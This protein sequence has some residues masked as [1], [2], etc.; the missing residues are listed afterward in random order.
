VVE[1]ILGKRA[2]GTE[3]PMRDVARETVE[4]NR[5]DCRIE[6]C[7]MLADQGSENSRQDI[8]ISADR[9]ARITGSI[10]MQPTAVGDDGA[11]SFENHD[12]SRFA[13]DLE[14]T[15]LLLVAIGCG[16]TG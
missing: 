11:V 4:I 9:H 10:F 15:L 5:E 6:G 16:N 1:Q 14:S 13:C 2:R 12:V 8:A 7:E 3:D